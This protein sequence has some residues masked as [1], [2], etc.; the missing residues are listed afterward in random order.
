MILERGNELHLL[1]GMPRAWC[2]PGAVNRLRGIPT[3]FGPVDLEVRVAADGRVATVAF[4][5]PAREPASRVVLH[6]ESF[7]RA[8]ESVRVNGAPVA[9]DATP[10]PPGAPARIEV[11]FAAGSR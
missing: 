5:P 7:G 8:A 1:E 2:R 9:R 11:Q 4:T 6:L 10:L 3:A